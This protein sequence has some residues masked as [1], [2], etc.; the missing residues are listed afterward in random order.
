VIPHAGELT[1]A[2]L[3]KDGFAMTDTCPTAQKI[4]RLVAEA[5][6]EI[7]DEQGLSP[8]EIKLRESFCWQLLRNVW[9]GAVSDA[10]NAHHLLIVLVIVSRIC[11]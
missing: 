10:L 4:Q 5:V 8:E 9:F 11:L 1:L 6:K 7:A 3:A 2:K